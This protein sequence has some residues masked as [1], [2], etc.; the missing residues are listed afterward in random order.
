MA[1]RTIT[2]LFD[3]EAQAQRARQQLTQRGLD[4]SQTR[5]VSQQPGTASAGS[6]SG[7][8]RGIL[9]SIRH[10]FTGEDDRGEYEEGL[11]R[12]GYLLVALIDEDDVDEAVV[13]ID[14][15]DPVDLRERSDQWRAEGWSGEQTEAM[16]TTPAAAGTGA[17][18]QRIPIAEEQ[19]QVGKRAIDR[20]TV[21]VRTYVVEQPVHEDV[22]L[23]DERVEIERRPASGQV[24]AADADA[25]TERTIEMTET[26]EEPVVAKQAVV[27]EEVV[28]RKFTGERTQG[29]DETVRRTEVDVDDSRDETRAAG[30]S[31]ARGKTA[32]KTQ[33][34]RPPD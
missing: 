28:I 20:G 8:H 5:V 30:P 10:F 18:E 14:S 13:I 29:V 4:E 33:E 25:L 23:R 26:S 31:A 21:R 3:S 6:Q 27:T 22:R 24:S 7:E 17:T 34:R 32:R 19:V 12:G 9:E 2:A 1:T 16:S 11:R 15:C